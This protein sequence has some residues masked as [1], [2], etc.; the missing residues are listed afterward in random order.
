MSQSPLIAQPAEN[1]APAVETGTLGLTAVRGGISGGKPNAARESSPTSYNIFQEAWWLDAVAEEDW[2]EVCVKRGNQIAARLPYVRKK[3]FGATLL[4]QPRLTPYLGPWV[5][6][7]TAKLTNRLAEE[8]ELMQELIDSLPSHDLFHQSFDPEIK[9]WLPFYWRGF[10]QTTRYTYRLMELGDLASLWLGVRENI[11]RE[12]RKAEKRVEV[13]TDLDIDD[14]ARVW[15]M[16]F[17]RQGQ[18]LPVRL[19]VLRRLDWACELHRCRRIFFAVDVGG[20]IHAAAY[21]VWNADRAYYLMG[22]ADPDLR[23]SGAASLVL[24]EAIQFASTVSKQFDFEG[25]MIEP[26]ER[27]FRAFGGQYVPYSTVSKF[28]RRLGIAAGLYNAGSAMLGRCSRI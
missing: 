4:L 28:G 20:K 10:Q 7:S 25:S 13:R 27:F 1:H 22:G 24:W 21:I 15:A 14:F 2:D 26:V 18:R 9:W 11:R 5:R 6:P 8:K 16:T 17:A 23:Q 12:I 3:K 19:Q